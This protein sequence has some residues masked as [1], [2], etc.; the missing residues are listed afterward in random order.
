[1]LNREQLIANMYT[2]L[3]TGCKTETVAIIDDS[4]QHVGHSG[5]QGAGHFT[6]NIVS[7]EFCDKSLVKR[8]QL[9]Y[10]ALGNY[11][12]QEIHALCIHAKT[13]DEI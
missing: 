4:A 5:H 10:Q 9:V 13:P 11:I 3:K 8:H 12:G 2:Q 1:M 6:V 7:T